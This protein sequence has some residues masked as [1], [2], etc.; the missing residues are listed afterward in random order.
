MAAITEIICTGCGEYLSLDDTY[1]GSPEWL[2]HA[3]DEAVCTHIATLMTNA[4]GPDTLNDLHDLQYIDW[5]A[6]YPRHRPTLM[7]ATV[8][9]RRGSWKEVTDGHR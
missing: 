8:E 2:D 7:F 5:N 4:L 6:I 9:M 1:S 3:W